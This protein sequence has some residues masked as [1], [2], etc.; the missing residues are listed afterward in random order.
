[1]RNP[2]Q[3]P[4]VRN[5]HCLSGQAEV[6]L[7]NGIRARAS[8][9]GYGLD[10]NRRRLHL[11]I[12]SAASVPF[13]LTGSERYAEVQKGG[14]QIHL[15]PDRMKVVGG[16]FGSIVIEERFAPR[17]QISC[18][19]RGFGWSRVASY[20]QSRGE[21]MS[22]KSRTAEDTALCSVRAR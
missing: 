8:A 4:F 16:S 6:D 19:C 21:L 15:P 14:S 22:K 3:K 2:Q 12:R 1:M 11:K 18:V 7:W 17:E 5:K 10:P 9:H 20:T 13:A